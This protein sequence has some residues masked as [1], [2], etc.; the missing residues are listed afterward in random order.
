VPLQA[1]KSAQEIGY[2]THRLYETV[3]KDISATFVLNLWGRSSLQITCSNLYNN[4]RVNRAQ[5]AA[6][7]F[8]S[9]KKCAGLKKRLPSEDLEIGAVGLLGREVQ[10]LSI[11]Y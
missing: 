2:G 6:F 10:P 11:S 1:K 8:S 3:S 4:I 5:T 9:P 7:S